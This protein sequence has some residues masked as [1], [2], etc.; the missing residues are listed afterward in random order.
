[1]YSARRTAEL[2]NAT[3]LEKRWSYTNDNCESN[4]SKTP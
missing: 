1:M 3:S 2:E 4:Q